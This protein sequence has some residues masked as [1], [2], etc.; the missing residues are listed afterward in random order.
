MTTR[1]LEYDRNIIRQETGYWC[2]PAST[3]VVLNS[4]GILVDESVLASEIGTTW[5]GT[6]YV[7]LIER[8]LDVRVPDARYTSVDMPNDPPTQE[9]KD[10]LWRD[11]VRSIDA[12]W[13]VIANIDAPPSNYPVAVPPSTTSPAYSG[14]EVFHYFAVMG[15]DDVTRAVWI[16]DSGFPPFGYWMSFDQLA[17]LI[18]PKGYCYA[19]VEPAPVVLA[20]APAGMTADALSRA[21]GGSLPLERYAELLPAFVNAMRAADCTTVERAAMW[22]AQIGHESAGLR[23]MEEIASGDAYD[24]RTDLGN[25]AAVDGDGRLYKGSGPIQLTGRANFRAFSQWCHEKGWVDSPTYFE[26]NPALVRTDPHW[27]FLAATWYWTVARPQLNALSDARN[28]EGA[29]R[30]IN[31]GLNGIAD[32]STRYQRCLD[33]GT[34][35]L[36]GDAG[37]TVSEYINQAAVQLHPFPGLIRQINRP[38]NVNESTRTPEGPWPG[39]EWADIW[40]EVVWDGFDIRPEYA[41]VP[42][43]VG[44]SLVALVMTIAARQVRDTNAEKAQLDRIESKLDRILGGK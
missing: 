41:E 40:N 37:E 38:Q 30:A 36:P 39:A 25:T 18:P 31:G 20:P 13:G 3:Q 26:D 8:V 42:D 24:T 29:T 15:Y 5:N 10:R 12:G 27:G 23:Y 9:Q 11:I 1:Q 33:M 35:L 6:D 16:A 17:T 4:R 34:A 14:G 21:M 7:G 44:R 19:D 2:G 28:L 22:C 43:D 32:R